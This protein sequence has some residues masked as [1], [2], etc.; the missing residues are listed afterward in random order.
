[1]GIHTATFKFKR[2]RVKLK[3]GTIIHDKF[4]DRPSH[5]RWIVL[6]EHGKIKREDIVSFSPISGQSKTLTQ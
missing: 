6:E 4:I 3:D 5:K 1:M 2:V